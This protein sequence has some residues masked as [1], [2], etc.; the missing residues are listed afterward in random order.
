MC[1]RSLRPMG[2]TLLLYISKYMVIPPCN[3][4]EQMPKKNRPMPSASLPTR[5]KMTVPEITPPIISTESQPF[6]T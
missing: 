6:W 5:G 4:G 3:F 1:A 2:K